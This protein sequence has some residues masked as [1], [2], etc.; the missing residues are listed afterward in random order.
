MKNVKKIFAVLMAVSFLL[1]PGL[2]SAA[3]PSPMD[4]P[5]KVPADGKPSAVKTAPKP[6]PAVNSG[7]PKPAQKPAPAQAKEGTQKGEER[8]EG[9]TG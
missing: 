5:T 1:L 9:K 7:Q 2:A 8:Q 3:A 4:K 6:E